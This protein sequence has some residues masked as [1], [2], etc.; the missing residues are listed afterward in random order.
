MKDSMMVPHAGDGNAI[1]RKLDVIERQGHWK[2][3]AGL[4]WSMYLGQRL[5]IEYLQPHMDAWLEKRNLTLVW[6]GPAGYLKTAKQDI[7]E[8]KYESLLAKITANKEIYML[9]RIYHSKNRHNIPL[10]PGSA[11]EAAVVQMME[12]FL[13]EAQELGLA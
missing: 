9:W 10:G 3:H 6:N 11:I 12:R 5:E 2:V 8:R 1:A 7:R 4:G 13:E